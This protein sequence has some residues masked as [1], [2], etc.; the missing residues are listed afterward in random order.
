MISTKEKDI[1]NTAISN[2]ALGCSFSNYQY[3]NG[4]LLKNKLS[5]VFK[6]LHILLIMSDDELSFFTNVGPYDNCHFQ[7]K[8]PNSFL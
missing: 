5:C 7:G 6:M 1:Y 2:N 4:L 3:A 8:Y